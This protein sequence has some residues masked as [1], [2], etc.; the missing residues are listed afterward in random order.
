MS[1]VLMAMW[2][3]APAGQKRAAIVSFLRSVQ[4]GETIVHGWKH[5]HSVQV[6]VGALGCRPITEVD[7][8]LLMQ[9][10][11]AD[12]SAYGQDITSRTHDGRVIN[13]CI[14]PKPAPKSVSLLD[15][16]G[17]DWGEMGEAARSFGQ[18]R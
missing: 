6:E 10:G 5:G 2:D 18:R 9:S 11:R 13:V 17:G 1:N 3:A 14:S 16:D 4:A 12:F 7:Y 15:E 8:A